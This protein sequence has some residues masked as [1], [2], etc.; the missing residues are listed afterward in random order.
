MFCSELVMVMVAFATAPPLE[1]ATVPEIVPVMFWLKAAQDKAT[2]IRK[3]HKNLLAKPFMKNLLGFP[4]IESRN[5]PT[6]KLHLEA[7]IL[8]LHT[9]VF[10]LHPREELSLPN[11]PKRFVI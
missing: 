8:V 5:S 6:R 2:V 1:S 11:W 4:A 10:M 3:V 9:P 7:R